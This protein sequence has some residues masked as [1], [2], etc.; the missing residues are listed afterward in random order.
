MATVGLGVV[1]SIACGRKVSMM[2]V[3]FLAG[4]LVEDQAGTENTHDLFPTLVHLA[5]GCAEG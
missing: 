1:R 5:R 2:K 4:G 3:L